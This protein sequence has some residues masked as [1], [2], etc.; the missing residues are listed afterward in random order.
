[1]FPHVVLG[2]ARKR[3]SKTCAHVCL[4]YSVLGRSCGYKRKPVF[5]EHFRPYILRALFFNRLK[6]YE[7]QIEIVVGHRFARL[8]QKTFYVEYFSFTFVR[9]A[10]RS[11]YVFAYPARFYFVLIYCSVKFHDNLSAFRT[12]RL[13][14]IVFTYFNFIC[15]SVSFALSDTFTVPRPN[16][17][18]SSMSFM[19]SVQYSGIDLIP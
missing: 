8:G 11:A 4:G 15:S 2:I 3:R 18:V 14:A 5:A 9:S 10:Y 16:T 19:G 12:A 17:V 7:L 13:N 6:P 1:M